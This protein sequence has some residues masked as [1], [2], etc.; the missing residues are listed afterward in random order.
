M[1]ERKINREPLLK[2]LKRLEFGSI[3]REL[4]LAELITVSYE[5][6]TWPLTDGAVGFVLSE[7]S[8]MWANLDEMA[9]ARAR[10]VSLAP[11]PPAATE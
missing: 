6:I 2:I 8:P 1:A 10:K 3:I 7:A 5:E 11:T 9:L 4:G